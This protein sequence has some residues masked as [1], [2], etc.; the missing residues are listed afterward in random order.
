MMKMTLIQILILQVY[1]D[2]DTKP[3]LRDK[4]KLSEKKLNSKNLKES[5]F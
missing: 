2:G 5:N 1:S 4:L 3:G